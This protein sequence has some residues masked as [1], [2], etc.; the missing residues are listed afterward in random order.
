MSA[1]RNLLG[2]QEEE[3]PYMFQIAIWAQI[4]RRVESLGIVLCQLIFTSSAPLGPCCCLTSTGNLYG[5]KSR[6]PN[7][8]TE[9][10][11]IQ[12]NIVVPLW[13]MDFQI[14]SPV[15]AFPRLKALEQHTH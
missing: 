10:I 3:H 15:T 13:T 1:L 8:I 7:H 4:V 12:K 9:S 2:A 14:K 5:R 6:L 11:V